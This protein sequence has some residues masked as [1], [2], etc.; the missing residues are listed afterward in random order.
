M[1]PHGSVRAIRLECGEHTNPVLRCFVNLEG[2]NCG[3][4]LVGVVHE[5]I[6]LANGLRLSTEVLSKDLSGA[7][8]TIQE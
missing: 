5:F 8:V 2:L 3:G 7:W 6:E 4:L 1:K